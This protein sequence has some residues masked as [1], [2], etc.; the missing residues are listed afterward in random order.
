MIINYQNIKPYTYEEMLSIEKD[1]YNKMLIA[2]DTEKENISIKRIKEH[3]I[4]VLNDKVYNMPQNIFI[5]KKYKGITIVGRKIWSVLSMDKRI[6]AINCSMITASMLLGILNTKKKDNDNIFVSYYPFTNGEK[7]TVFDDIKHSKLDIYYPFKYRDYDTKKEEVTPKEGWTF[8]LDKKEYLGYGEKHIREYT[9]KYF[10]EY[11]LKDKR[12]YDPACSTGEFL[13]TFQNKHKYCYT[14]GHDLSEQMIEYAK[15]YVD[16]ALCTDAYK[17][18]IKDRSI[19]I[20]FLRFLN[21]EVVST[22]MAHKI[23]RVLLA[24]MKHRGIVVCFGHTPVLISKEWFLKNGLK[25]IDTIGYSKEYDAI[26]QYYVL[27]VI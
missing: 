15:D 4:E 7:L 5:I 24:K 19:D 17:S 6:N 20:M 27:E 21:S 9:T 14:I 16:E 26:F 8:N 22:N 25:V 13:N 2:K 12:I 18:P 10:K 3:S 11:N 1:I 23:M